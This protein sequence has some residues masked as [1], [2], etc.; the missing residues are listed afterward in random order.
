MYL[1]VTVRFW[2]S[3]N[4]LAQFEV[5]QTEHLKKKHLE[6]ESHTHT[7]KL[8]CR[9]FMMYIIYDIYYLKYI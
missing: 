8:I 1:W 9:L 3:L 2:K 6:R 4:A 7:K 5:W